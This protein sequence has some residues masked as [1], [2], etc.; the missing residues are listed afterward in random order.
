LDH[1]QGVDR[2]AQEAKK[3]GLNVSSATQEAIAAA[4]AQRSTNAWL[5]EVNVKWK[6]TVSHEAVLDALDAGHDEAPTRHG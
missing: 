1:S 2:L 4:L 5:V 6:R 3:V